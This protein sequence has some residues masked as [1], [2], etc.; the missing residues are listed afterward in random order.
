MKVLDGKKLSEDILSEIF[1]S[2]K[3]YNFYNSDR[4][5]LAIV[6]KAVFIQLGDDMASNTYIT[7]KVIAMCK[8]GFEYHIHKLGIDTSEEE[9][10]ELIYKLNADRT[11]H[12]IM[13]QLPL[14]NHINTTRIKESIFIEK[15]IDGFN[16]INLGLACMGVTEDVYLPATPAGI[17]EMIDRYELDLDGKHVVVLGRSETVGRPIANILSNKQYNATVTLCHSH[18]KDVSRYTKMADLIICAI[19]KANYLTSDMVTEGVT[20]IDVGINRGQDGKLCGDCDKSVHS[21]AEYVSP[22]PGGV[23]PMTVAMLMN[24]ILKAH[25]NS[26][27]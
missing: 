19:G 17:M 6:P 2:S 27:L 10:C 12:G 13:V 7:N 11:V 25:T 5:D 24:N 23:G 4:E 9:L 8:C 16:P 21:V 3:C 22:V 20:I 1:E 26:L 15:D 18:T 14:P